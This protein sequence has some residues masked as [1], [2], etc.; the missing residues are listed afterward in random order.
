MELKDIATIAGKGGLFRIL[1]PTRNGVILETLDAQ[2]AKI[3]AGASSR[4][5]ILQEISIYTTSK[6]ASVLLE[7]VFKDI[8]E[9]HNGATIP[10]SA[11]SSEKELKDF[12][13][14]IIP[15]YDESRVYVS[16]LKKLVTWYNTLVQ[17]APDLFTAAEATAEAK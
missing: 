6:E 4:V 16:D 9:K 7:K 15:D 11:K 2:K 1:K 17:F 13:L 8:Y 14:T 10:L 5:S 12:V 3:I